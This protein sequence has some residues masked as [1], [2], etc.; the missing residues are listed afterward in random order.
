MALV[1]TCVG[2]QLGIL[3]LVGG[4]IVRQILTSEDWTELNR[5]T[6]RGN[7]DKWMNE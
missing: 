7:V 2:G 3:E 5:L 6:G 4:Q 1:E